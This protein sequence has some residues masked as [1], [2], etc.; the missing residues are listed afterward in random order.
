MTFEQHLREGRNHLCESLENKMFL[1]EQ[2]VQYPGSRNDHSVFQEEKEG[3]CGCREP[4]SRE[5]EWKD[6]KLEK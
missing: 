5:R 6:M 2:Q 4:C 3:S 1:E